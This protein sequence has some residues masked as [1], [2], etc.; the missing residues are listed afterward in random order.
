MNV[1]IF[2][3]WLVDAAVSPF[4]INYILGMASI[5]KMKFAGAISL[6]FG[7]NMFL[8]FFAV[9]ERADT[10]LTA[11]LLMFAFFAVVSFPFMYFLFDLVKGQH[12]E[13]KEKKGAGK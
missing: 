3:I 6:G 9:W 7:A 8:L 4:F 5:T 13:R 12:E 11:S 10:R 2:I 1:F